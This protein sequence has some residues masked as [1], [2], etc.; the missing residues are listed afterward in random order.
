MLFSIV[1]QAGALQILPGTTLLIPTNLITLRQLESLKLRTLYFVCR[2]GLI[3]IVNPNGN[4]GAELQ[5]SVGVGLALFC[6]L[7]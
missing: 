6:L 1:T 2:Q 4:C 7:D 5:M 3:L